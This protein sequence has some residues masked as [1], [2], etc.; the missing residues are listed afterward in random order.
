MVISYHLFLELSGHT[1]YWIHVIIE[2][3][4]DLCVVFSF[5]FGMVKRL[6]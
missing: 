3:H 2:K 6:A 1:P 4:N 5:T